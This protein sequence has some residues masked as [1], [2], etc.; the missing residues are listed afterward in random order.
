LQQAEQKA[1]FWVVKDR[2]AR[3]REGWQWVVDNLGL[4]GVA[5]GDRSSFPGVGGE[6]PLA[7]GMP[8]MRIHNGYTD[9]SDGICQFWSA[10]ELGTHVNFKVGGKYR[11]TLNARGVCA[12]EEWPVLNLSIGKRKLGSLTIASESFAEYQ[13]D[14][15]IP[16]G[17]WQVMLA[18]RN[19]A[20]GGKR[21]LTV[22]DIK[23]EKI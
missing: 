20:S 21:Q 7:L 19:H 2:I 15:E 9:I 8:K 23:I 1:R 10:G 11:L 14:G 22:K 18:F 6:S 17:I 5:L 16:E 12:E 3:V 13:F 4:K